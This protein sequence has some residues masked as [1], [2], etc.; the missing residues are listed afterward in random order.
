MSLI[1]VTKFQNTIFAFSDTKITFDN[2]LRLSK[3]SMNFV[4]KYGVIKTYILF[5]GKVLF[6]FAGDEISDANELLLQIQNK[7]IAEILE[8][9]LENHMSHN[10][11]TDFIFG[12]IGDKI[13]LFEIKN[14]YCQEVDNS[15]VGHSDAFT[16]FNAIRH[17]NTNFI[18]ESNDSFSY[19]VSSG[20]Y[21]IGANKL[22]NEKYEKL[23]NAFHKTIN[24]CGIEGVGG[25][26]IPISL[27]MQNRTLYRPPYHKHYSHF[28][29][30][31]DGSTKNILDMSSRIGAYSISFYGSNTNTVGLYISQGNLGVLYNNA[32]LDIQDYN[33]YSIPE[34]SLPISTKMHHFDFFTQVKAQGLFP[35]MWRD[36]DS[37][38]IEYLYQKAISYKNE[39]KLNL[40]IIYLNEIIQI[41]E[42]EHRNLADY[43]Y[44]YKEKEQI[45]NLH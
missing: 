25:F 7:S 11:R 37:S 16:Y 3:T 33:Q 42:S 18:L 26:V 41:I 19:E 13:H 27:N 17:D 44:I 10:N 36:F 8:I 31:P 39:N 4:Q 5:G 30:N 12:F 32:R 23:F 35:P 28:E 15:Y 34:L 21:L 45:T 40:A 9:A 2:Y 1:Y 6:A 38:N 20:T 43:E 29:I 22:I 14:G 24:D